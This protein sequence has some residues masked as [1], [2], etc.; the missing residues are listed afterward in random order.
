MMPA[1]HVRATPPKP[2]TTVPKQ[3][4]NK[5]DTNGH[6]EVSWSLYEELQLTEERWEWEKWSSPG[7]STA[8]G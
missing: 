4:L 8:I 7:K 3:E 5:D 1:S 6:T 2:H